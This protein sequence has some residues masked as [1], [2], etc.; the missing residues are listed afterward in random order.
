MPTVNEVKVLVLNHFISEY[1]DETPFTFDNEAFTAPDEAWVRI[2]VRNRI[3]NQDS[4]GGANNRKFL[5]E[6]VVFAQIFVPADRGTSEA[7]RLAHIIRN[8]FEGRRLSNQ[9]WF[10]N[11]D[12]REVGPD[13]NEYIVLVES[14]FNYEEIK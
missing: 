1:N 7:D 3:S 14:I 11:S 13:G 12:V 9:V 10:I 8:I 4:F 5:R 6:G 2:A